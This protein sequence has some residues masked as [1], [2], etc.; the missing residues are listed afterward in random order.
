VGDT[1]QFELTDGLLA[2]GVVKI[3]Q[4]DADGVTYM[5]RELGVPE[6]G[7]LFFL[8]PPAGGRA[9]SAVGVIERPA[10]KTAYRIE[11]TGENGAPELWKRVA[12]DYMPFNIN[13][14]T[15]RKVYEAAPA[16][17]RQRCVF[18]P[19]TTA[20]GPGAAVYWP[21]NNLNGA[22]NEIRI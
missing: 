14:T 11:S 9:G 3:V 20:I 5:S 10:S 21:D 2:S 16:S 1:L 15:D 12:E 17:S 7:K 13:V 6:S 18:T 19:S 8:R 22:I 4:R